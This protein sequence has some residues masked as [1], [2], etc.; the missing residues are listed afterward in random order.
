VK[1][2]HPWRWVI[3]AAVV[4]VAAVSAVFIVR[5]H[6]FHDTSTALRVDQAVDRYRASTTVAPSGPTTT[7]TAMPA[8]VRLPAAGVYRYATTGSEHIDALQG[9]RHRYPAETT[10]T[11]TPATCGVT[12]RWDALVERWDGR[13]LC[14]HDGALVTPGYRTFHRF[15]G[16]DDHSDWTC[17]PPI[18]WQPARPVVGA[19]WTGAC[20]DN[21]TAER[22]TI[23]VVG[24]ERVTVAGASVETM[25]ARWIDADS[26]SDTTGNTTTD[27]WTRVSDGLV[28]REVVESRSTTKTVIGKVH[29]DERYD[30]RLESLQPVR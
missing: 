19:A 8:G 2:R 6:F 17:A 13:D 15:F 14:R 16:Q 11:V 5:E 28:V 21:G 27:R 26:A 29:Y 23:T 10:M 9:T 20:K 18:V 30:V 1:R 22:S 4:V 24:L 7:T 3:V 25:H 12:V